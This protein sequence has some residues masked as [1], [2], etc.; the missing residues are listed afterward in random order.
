MQIP[1]PTDVQTMDRPG[2]S[3][4][5]LIVEDDCRVAGEMASSLELAGYVVS[6]V[7]DGL[8]ALDLTA[9]QGF[10]VM[11]VDRMLPRLDGVSFVRALRTRGNTTPVLLVTALGTVADR[12]V[13]LE[14]GADDYL[15]KPFAFDE[16]HARVRALKRRSKDGQDEPTRLVCSALVMNRLARQV[17]W[18]GTEI[19]LLPLEYQLLEVLLLNAGRPVT[20]MMLLEQVWGFRFDPRTNIVE[21]HIS[22]L[23]TKLEAAGAQRLVRTIRG[24]GYVINP[25]PGPTP[26]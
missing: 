10:D 26:A 24:S 23:R 7:E 13:G 22:H 17:R 15:V 2:T 6:V 19:D 4:A 8:V 18:D 25:D 12:V 1:G 20:R 11:I 14:S 16:L 9:A 5:I 3:L 21:T